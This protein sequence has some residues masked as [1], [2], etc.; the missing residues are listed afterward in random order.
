ME[1]AFE[2]DFNA[3]QL[4]IGELKSA[5]DDL[6]DALEVVSNQADSSK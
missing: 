5:N 4:E 6:K 2:E 3:K 1:S